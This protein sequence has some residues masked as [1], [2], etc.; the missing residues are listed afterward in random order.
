MAVSNTPGTKVWG[1]GVERGAI[2][3]GEEQEAK[4]TQTGI[5]EKME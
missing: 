3:Y 2:K 1:K 4:K 5:K